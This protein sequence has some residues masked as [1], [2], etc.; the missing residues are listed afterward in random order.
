[1]LLVAGERLPAVAAEEQVRAKGHRSS[2]SRSELAPRGCALRARTILAH[3][4]HRTGYRT[5]G[6][7][8]MSRTCPRLFVARIPGSA[9][10]GGPAA[11]PLQD[12]R[13]AAPTSHG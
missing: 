11:P 2:W 7:G 1:D 5:K 8:I 9:A 12:R 4:T 13:A 10:P 3:G 6:I